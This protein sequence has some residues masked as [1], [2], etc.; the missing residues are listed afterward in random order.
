MPDF[1]AVLGL[2]TFCQRVALGLESAGFKVLAVDVSE[3]R[4]HAIRDEVTKA[5]CGDLR[6]REMLDEIGVSECSTAV[7]GLPDH[8]D[9]GVLVVHYLST[10]NVREIIVQVNTEDQAA[11]IEKVGA[12][13]TVFP[14]RV[15]AEQQVRSMTLPG[16]L[17]R[18]DVS[19]D[20]AI[21]E[22]DCPD[23]F[24]GQSLKG[25]DLRKKYN[26]HVVGLIRKPEKQGEKSRT[27]LAPPAEE[28]L[29]DGDVLMV[30]GTTGRLRN[31]TIQMEKTRQAEGGRAE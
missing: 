24:I 8:F 10:H 14:E 3:S 2:S 23:N 27:I 26:V 17:D 7:L 18:I 21:I 1:V 28:P 15:A 6:D 29:R 4:V 20:A 5:F 22:V 19:E 11:A 12:T 31:F 30:L 9:I 13:K 25:L 16:L